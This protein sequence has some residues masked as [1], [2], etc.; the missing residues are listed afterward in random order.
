MWHDNMIFEKSHTKKP[1]SQKQLIQ[2]DVFSIECLY[3]RKPLK[4]SF[5]FKIIQE[6]APKTLNG[7]LTI[8]CNAQYF[9]SPDVH[10]STIPEWAV[11]RETE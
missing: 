10:R 9:N 5:F 1:V 3:S 11:L 8:F 2:T 7:L 4:L 6:T